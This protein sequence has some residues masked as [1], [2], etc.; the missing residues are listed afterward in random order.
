MFGRRR[1]AWFRFR[2]EERR[3]PRGSTRDVEGRRP[4]LV[5]NPY[6]STPGVSPTPCSQS[7]LQSPVPRV[8]ER[9]GAF[10]ST[11]SRPVSPLRSRFP[12]CDLRYPRSPPS[13]S[14]TC[15]KTP[16][17]RRFFPGSPR[18]VVPATES[19]LDVVSD[20]GPGTWADSS[21]GTKGPGRGR[22]PGL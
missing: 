13:Q 10:R 11:T 6:K 22:T 18:S 5:P 7:D 15:S 8:Y 1:I 9:G 3:R 17:I 12:S 20:K 16:F 14:G 2:W 4:R 21:S 19:P